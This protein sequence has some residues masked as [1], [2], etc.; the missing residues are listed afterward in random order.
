MT[1]WILLGSMMMAVHGHPRFYEGTHA[2]IP[3]LN[4]GRLHMLCPSANCVYCGGACSWEDDWEH[5]HDMDEYEHWMQ[6]P[7]SPRQR[8]A[9]PEQGWPDD[10]DLYGDESEVDCDD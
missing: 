10:E 3:R 6:H 9:D 1:K 8:F 2:A 5:Y 4:Q 7:S